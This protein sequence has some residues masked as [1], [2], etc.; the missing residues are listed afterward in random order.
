METIRLDLDHAPGLLTAAAGALEDVGTS[1]TALAGVD[2]PVD[3]GAVTAAL[4]LVEDW[5]G[6]FQ[7]GFRTFWELVEALDARGAAVDAENVLTLRAPSAGTLDE[8]AEAVT[9]GRRLGDDLRDAVADGDV[10]EVERLLGDLADAERDLVAD[11]ALFDALGPVGL[12]ELDALLATYAPEP[13][14]VDPAG[15]SGG[16]WRAVTADGT[17]LVHPAAA[18][19]L[20]RFS[21]VDRRVGLPDD[22]RRELVATAE[23]ATLARIARLGEVSPVSNELRALSAQHVAWHA[24]SAPLDGAHAEDVFRDAARSPEAARRALV[25]EYEGGA[26][27]DRLFSRPVQVDAGVADAVG[28]LVV[29]AAVRPAGGPQGRGLREEAARATIRAVA[30][31]DAWVG[32]GARPALADLYGAHIDDF[33]HAVVVAP[34]AMSADRL[35]GR[36]GVELGGLQARRYLAEVALDQDAYA[37]VVAAT[38]ARVAEV[39]AAGNERPVGGDFDALRLVATRYAGSL[40]GLVYGGLGDG[41]HAAGLDEDA[42][43]RAFETVAST[44]RG[45]VTNPQ[46]AVTELA[47]GRAQSLFGDLLFGDGDA[48]AD[49]RARLGSSVRSLSADELFDQAAPAYEGYVVAVHDRGAADAEA[50]R[51]VAEAQAYDATLPADE[52]FLAGDGTLHP[53]MATDPRRRAQ[54]MRLAAGE[55]GPDRLGLASI[56][57]PANLS[58]ASHA[59]DYLALYPVDGANA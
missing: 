57:D 39:V 15:V 28:A 21:V 13:D 53:D 25:G 47:L 37:G 34:D 44:A 7:S 30:R 59:V 36:P 32:D 2:G 24:D 27:A 9:G 3:L 22:H 56:T 54:F 35:A 48:A 33:A 45:A 6:A 31:D 20:T 17:R 52:R 38:E 50:A 23:P 18:L 43:R 46:G 40:Q 12:A 4:A 5:V 42:R 41:L 51:V 14:G 49:A 11:A 29:A 16:A 26:T 1:R 8:L 10:D 55:V 58:A 19:L